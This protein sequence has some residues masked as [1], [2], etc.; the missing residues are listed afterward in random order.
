MKTTRRDIIKMLSLAIAG[1]S[2]P[3][4]L[5]SA[6]IDPN[7]AG[8]KPFE[9]QSVFDPKTGSWNIEWPGKLSQYDLAYLSP[10]VD[11]LQ[12]I[13]IGNGDIG[14]LL[15]CEESKIIIVLNKCDLWDDAAFE[16][17]HNWDAAEEDVSTTLRH[18]CRIIIDFKYPVFSTL[19]LS[20]FHARLN[21]CDASIQLTSDSPFGTLGIKLFIDYESGAILCDVET[22]FKEELDLPVYME[23]F[24]SRTFSHWYALI[25]RDAT[26][27]TNG[28]Q[29]LADE[30]G[31]YITQQLAANSFA[32]GGS[33]VK[34][35]NLDVRY[36][37]EHSRSAAITIKNGLK[38][39]V[40]LCFKIT[41]PGTGDLLPVLK[42]ALSG[43][44]AKGM[45]A[46]II[47]NQEKWK[48]LWSRS[49]IDFGDD[50]LN[51]LW[52]LTMYYAITS[53]GGKYPGRF[54]NGLWAWSRDVQN[55]NFY[56]HWNQQ[57]IYWPLNAAGYHEL[58]DP[59]L[60]YRFRS[61]PHA[62]M[63]AESLFKAKGAFIADVADRR[64]NNSVNEKDNHTPVAEIALDFWRQ[65]QYTQDKKFLREKT[66]PFI[67]EAARYFESLFKKAD[68]GLYHA[69]EGTGYEGWIKLKDGLT[70]LVYGRVLFATALSALKI[71]GTEL[72]ES[73]KW[74]DILDHLAPLPVVKAG[75]QS[76]TAAGNGYKINRGYFKGEEVP[77]DD[78]MSA[79][80]GIKENKL[81][82]V[83]T[84]A[85]NGKFWGFD[86]LD[87]IFPTV[88]AAPVFPSGLV[89]LSQKDNTENMFEVLKTTTLLYGPGI[90]GWDPSPVVM[91]RL[92]MA[93]ELE[94]TIKIF[95]DRWQI[96]CNGWGHWGMEHEIKKDAEWFFRTNTVKETKKDSEKFP[97]PVWPFRH[98]SMESMSVF[99][100]ALNESLL[101]SHDGILRIAPAIT[102][103][104]SCRFTLHAV[105]GFIVS[106]E[107]IKGSAVWV[108]I[109]S[110]AGGI[111]RVALPWKNP[112]IFSSLRKSK[113]TSAGP[114]A[115]IKTQPGET[116][117]LL[118]PGVS[119]ADWITKQEIKQPNGKSKAY[120]QGTAHLGLPRMF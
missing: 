34:H 72:P 67:I 99:A 62:K 102:Q 11:P 13:P 52:Y 114:V 107:I 57:Q 21:L 3:F 5:Y 63:D 76:I 7:N 28:C 97:I 50:Y 73:A 87:G 4:G 2:L 46:F 101:Q 70:E 15:W 88:A 91:A 82:T 25:N 95:P 90:T 29:A 115:V 6:A 51:N 71:S 68:D 24:G 75:S 19:Y 60:D 43:I 120:A 66:L 1:N 110:K 69:T 93:R 18:A 47:T 83:Y 84:E 81:L 77:T 116:I 111:C 74:K 38:K 41:D 45:E 37:R 108:S 42:S 54:N 17:F 14:G 8:K 103:E 55:W 53:Q 39:Q 30:Q 35:N 92:G 58:V 117:T 94:K 100:T 112:G 85:E 105:G 48:S 96:Y 65:Y 56:F 98:M 64:G 16:R 10:P 12:G 78:I 109:K 119:M 26:I 80:W 36:S 40:Q 9:L 89:G 20:D 44:K 31:I 32:V 86:L 59:Y 27:G 22:Q 104:R 49:F 106:A 61:L 113:T 33:V 118:Q 23:R 79:G